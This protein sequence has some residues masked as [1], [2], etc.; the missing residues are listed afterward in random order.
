MDFEIGSAALAGLISGGV[1]AAILYMTM[2][3]MP[4]QMKMNMFMLLGSM[5]MPVGAPAFLAG[6]M[7]HS[8]MSIVFGLA[9]AAVFSVAEIDSAYA[10]WGLLFG[11]VHW[12]IV[13]MA[14]GMLPL[15]HKRIRYGGFRL[16]PAVGGNPHPE[17]LLDPPGFYALGYPLMTVAGSL[18][19]H[20]LFG[21]IFGALYGAWT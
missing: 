13:G 16:V 12:G 19:L 5:M 15:M 1:M 20:L 9:H 7:I 18:M 2:I 10:A 4:A 6:A 8:G 3:V 11:L 17:T 14:L 21:V